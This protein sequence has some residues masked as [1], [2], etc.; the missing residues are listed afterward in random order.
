MPYRSQSF[1]A[2]AI[3]L[4][5][6]TACTS[7]TGEFPTIENGANV[8]IEYTLTLPDGTEVD[9]NVGKDPLPFTQGKGQ[10]I[11]GLE[12]QIVGMKAGDTG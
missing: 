4:I 2:L 9:S 3:T 1:M 11:S 5:A 10:I 12:R 6:F 8:T 7:K